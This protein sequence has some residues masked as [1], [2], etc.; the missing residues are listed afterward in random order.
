MSTQ[1]GGSKFKR[2][3]IVAEDRETDVAPST[4]ETTDLARRMIVIDL[5]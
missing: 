4:E 2:S 5:H 3:D 1:V